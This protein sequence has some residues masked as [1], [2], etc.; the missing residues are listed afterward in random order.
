M[1][2]WASGS[3]SSNLAHGHHHLSPRRLGPNSTPWAD[4]RRE[5]RDSLMNDR[6]L[7]IARRLA[8]ARSEGGTAWS[9]L[10]VGEDSGTSS[11]GLGAAGIGAGAASQRR[12]RARNSSLSGTALSRRTAPSSGSGGVGTTTNS[13]TGPRREHYRN[14]MFSSDVDNVT[15]FD[16]TLTNTG[17]PTSNVDE[18]QSLISPHSTATTRPR[19]LWTVDPEAGRR[20]GMILN[21][22]RPNHSPSS[23]ELQFVS[24]AAAP[25][26]APPLGDRSSQVPAPLNPAD[27]MTPRRSLGQPGVS[28]TDLRTQLSGR[29][30]RLEAVRE[31]LLAANASNEARQGQESNSAALSTAR[32]AL[33]TAAVFA[34]RL[35]QAMRALSLLASDA[36]AVTPG[37][38]TSTST[39][40]SPPTVSQPS[41]STTT[42]ESLRQSY[43]DLARFP[44]A[45]SATE[46]FSPSNPPGESLRA[47]ARSS[48]ASLSLQ[49]SIDQLRAASA[50]IDQ[51]LQE[52]F[53]V[54]V[55]SS[56]T[57]LNQNMV[58]RSWSERQTALLA[59]S[60]TVQEGDSSGSEE[61]GRRTPTPSTPR[62]QSSRIVTGV[63]GE[64]ERTRL[65]GGFER[66]DSWG[67][68]RPRGGEPVV[69]PPTDS[70]ARS[71]FVSTLFRWTS[72]TDPSNHSSSSQQA[73]KQLEDE[74]GASDDGRLWQG[75][76]TGGWGRLDRNGD[77]ILSVEEEGRRRRLPRPVCGR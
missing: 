71:A 63:S 52:R 51:I 7:E 28:M 6:A 43:L 76:L 57:S 3:A 12:E 47:H 2:D 62:V 55:G 45:V 37:I 64:R 41:S 67:S 17:T 15:P 59:S 58:S 46:T 75:G 39:P 21:P 22:I 38:S 42:D 65:P 30:E 8:A 11:A 9:V 36:L 10:G 77:P 25:T 32:D 16:S 60:Q 24:M 73:Q 27:S 14:S 53:G 68:R 1:S 54:A 49:R 50:R 29:V 61:E 74:E 70:Q 35:E 40:S 23:R 5:Q 34:E 33:Q 44:T 69:P 31:R 13:G 18:E 48:S 66:P 56:F 72:D 26:P 19:P 4:R 20:G